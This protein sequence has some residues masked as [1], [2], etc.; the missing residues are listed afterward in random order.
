MLR[1]THIRI[2]C[3]LTVLI[4]EPLTMSCWPSFCVILMRFWVNFT[5]IYA[6]NSF[7]V[8]QVTIFYSQCI[9]PYIYGTY[10]HPRYITPFFIKFHYYCPYLHIYFTGQPWCVSGNPMQLPHEIQKHAKGLKQGQ[11]IKTL[12]HC[13]ELTPKTNKTPLGIS[14]LSGLLQTLFHIFCLSWR[15]TQNACLK[16]SLRQSIN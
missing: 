10:S 6:S 12:W 13:L 5:Q 16:H 8:Q 15:P 4:K 14:R 7:L 3:P 9:F 1:P 11:P 2:F